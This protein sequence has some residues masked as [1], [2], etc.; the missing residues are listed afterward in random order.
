MLM[1]LLRHVHYKS[2]AMAMAITLLLDSLT[3]ILL[4]LFMGRKALP[5][6]ASQADLQKAFEAVSQQPAY[7]GASLLLGSAST[8]LG[9]YLAAR[10]AG[11]LPYLN[12]AAYG[13]LGLALVLWLGAPDT[14]L[15]FDLLGDLST[16]PLALAGGHW[17]RQQQPPV[18]PDAKR[19]GPH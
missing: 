9:G 13:V 14:P 3:G 1:Q 11:R 2:V 16:L 6:G 8:L 15:W 17:A 7:L 5:P 4:T 12:S 10:M 18:R 19:P